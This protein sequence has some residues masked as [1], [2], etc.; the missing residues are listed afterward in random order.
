MSRMGIA[1][2][3]VIAADTFGVTEHRGVRAPAVPEELDDGDRDREADARDRAEDRDPDQTD[4][5]QPEF[6]TLDAVDSTQVG[7]FQ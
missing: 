3:V 4:D 6:P 2:D 5:R 7:D 1:R